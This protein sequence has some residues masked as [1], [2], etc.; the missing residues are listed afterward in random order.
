MR[1]CEVRWGI[2]PGFKELQ[3]KYLSMTREKKKRHLRDTKGVWSFICP[4]R[5]LIL[6][7][8]VGEEV[9]V[10]DVVFVSSAKLPRVRKRLG[11]PV[12]ISAF[13]SHFKKALAQYETYAVIKTPVGS[14]KRLKPT[15]LQK[16]E[17]ACCLLRCGGWPFMKRSSAWYLNSFGPPNTSPRTEQH[18]LFVN[19]AEKSWVGERG[20]LLGLVPF[21]LDSFWKGFQ[22][23]GGFLEDLLAFLAPKSAVQQQWKAQVRQAAILLGQSLQT[24]D[25]GIAFLLDMIA[26]DILLLE[27]TENAE[28]SMYERLEALMGWMNT[29]LPK[30]WFTKTAVRRLRTLRNDIVHDGKTTDIKVRDLLLADELAMNLVM[31]ICLLRKRWGNRSGLIELTEKLKACEALQLPPSFSRKLRPPTRVIRPQYKQ[32]DLSDLRGLIGG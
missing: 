17:E 29:R 20:W 11:L 1:R 3:W 13:G 22:Q 28:P 9:C 31:N 19:R 25:K 5:N 2:Y 6:T 10:E 16:V 18:L 26:L 14:P 24:L 15:L 12:Q 32:K 4:I 21:A 8:D 7:K 23:E 27:R 30:P